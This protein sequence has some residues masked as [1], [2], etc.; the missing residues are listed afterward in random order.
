MELCVTSYGKQCPTRVLTVRVYVRAV[1]SQNAL[2]AITDRTER[3]K[4]Q[5]EA[6]TLQCTL[7]TCLAG[8]N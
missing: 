1:M 8:A 6:E 3:A 5:E 7:L 2:W 4:C